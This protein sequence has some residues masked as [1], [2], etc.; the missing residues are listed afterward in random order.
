MLKA[1]SFEVDAEGPSLG[2]CSEDS[3]SKIAQGIQSNISLS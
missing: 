1:I 2:A 3:S